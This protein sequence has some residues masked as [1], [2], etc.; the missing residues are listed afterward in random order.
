MA[1]F[2][3]LRYVE[4]LSR[5]FP[6]HFRSARVL[7]IGSLD[8]NGSIRSY[9]VDCDYVGLDVAPG[10]GVDVV[11]EGQKFEAPD[12]TYD[13]VISCEAMEHNP[14][15]VAT[16]KNMI[17][18]CRPG[19]LVIMTCATTGRPEHGTTRT[20]PE[21]SPLT[22]GLGWNYYRN[23]RERDFRRKVDTSACARSKYWVRWN[24]FDLLFLGIKGSAD[25]SAELASAWSQSVADIDRWIGEDGNTRALRYRAKAAPFLGDAWFV[26]M[27]RLT[28]RLYRLISLMERLHQPHDEDRAARPP[29]E[30]QAGNR[31]GA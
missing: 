3:Q 10:K 18:M 28:V 16:F 5:R 8:I 15:W 7:E 17:R 25:G 12:D 21:S 6:A 22:V 27:R 1:H 23:L 11:C 20:E 19:G 31:T 30:Q 29:A 26:V 24:H 13:V 2:S 9:F 4:L 14:H